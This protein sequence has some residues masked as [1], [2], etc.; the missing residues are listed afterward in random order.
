MQPSLRETVEHF[1]RREES[2]LVQLGCA[3]DSAR[4]PDEILEPD[5]RQS[6]VDLGVRHT[7][8]ADSSR[9]RS[10]DADAAWLHHA[11]RE[12]W[13]DQHDSVRGQVR[14]EPLERAA[15]IV[16]RSYISD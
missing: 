9:F 4:S 5:P 6:A 10:I 7:R 8:D 3:L 16:Q 1:L 13:L 2:E 14:N 15:D 12:P 11:G